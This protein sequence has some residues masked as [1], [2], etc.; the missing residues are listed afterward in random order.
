MIIKS[1]TK[2]LRLSIFTSLTL[3]NVKHNSAVEAA[4]D[5]LTKGNISR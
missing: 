5:L 4:I 2:P 1:F 3:N